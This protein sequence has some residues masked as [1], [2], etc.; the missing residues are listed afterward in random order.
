MKLN[1]TSGKCSKIETGSIK[2]TGPMRSAI[3]GVLRRWVVITCDLV[4]SNR[5]YLGARNPSEELRTGNSC[6]NLQ[7]RM[8]GILGRTSGPLRSVYGGS[9]RFH[10]TALLAPVQ[11]VLF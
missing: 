7:F 10:N 11:N 2:T 8:N 5:K 9:G 4:V 1:A 6:Y 3:D